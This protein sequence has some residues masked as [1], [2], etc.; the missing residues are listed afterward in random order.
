[1]SQVNT[2]LPFMLSYYQSQ[3]PDGTHVQR[4]IGDK[5]EKL[6]RLL[7][8]KAIKEHSWSIHSHGAWLKVETDNNELFERIVIV[9]PRPE[10]H[11][12]KLFRPWA[13][14]R[15]KHLSRYVERTNAGRIVRF[16]VQ[17]QVVIAILMARKGFDLQDPQ[18]PLPE[19][20]KVAQLLKL[21]DREINM[22]IT[23]MSD[24]E[25]SFIQALKLHKI[26]QAHNPPLYKLSLDILP[27]VLGLKGK[28]PIPLHPVTLMR[29]VVGEIAEQLDSRGVDPPDPDARG[30][31]KL[32][33]RYQRSLQRRQNEACIREL[34]SL[35]ARID[36]TQP[37]YPQVSS[38]LTEFNGGKVEPLVPLRLVLAFL[39]L[40]AALWVLWLQQKGG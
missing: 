13:E 27:T 38:W 24:E 32:Y 5:S 19:A 8:E 37:S 7:G 28:N 12:P 36:L 29:G 25:L 22:Y 39:C 30:W 23:W 15:L 1:L 4:Y 21:F 11:S 14:G 35:A 20:D 33:D 3:R 6:L 34:D 17:K 40:A 26:P 18:C 2:H 10:Q 16:I 31:R 9:L